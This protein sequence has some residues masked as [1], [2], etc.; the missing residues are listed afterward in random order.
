MKITVHLIYITTRLYINKTYLVSSIKNG[1]IKGRK[2]NIHDDIK[3]T[4]ANGQ[5][6]INVGSAKSS[7]INVYGF[8]WWHV[9]EQPVHVHGFVLMAT[10]AII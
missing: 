1:L 9:L 8:M 5:T 6:I 10:Q 3:R 7:V 2:Y 4:A